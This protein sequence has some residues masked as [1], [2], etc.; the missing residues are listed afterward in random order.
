[1]SYGDLETH[2]GAVAESKDV[3]LVD[4]Q[5]P[6]EDRNVVSGGF[7]C[8]RRIAIRRPAV[9]LLLHRDDPAGVGKDREHSLERHLDGRPTTVK[10]NERNPVSA[11]VHFVVHVDAVDRGMAAL[12][13]LRLKAQHVVSSLPSVINCAARCSPPVFSAQAHTSRI[14]CSIPVAE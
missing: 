12:Q 10:Q 8:D 13:R 2:A 11:P 14:A 4:L 9:S 6:K 7:E 3:S 5:V 1:M